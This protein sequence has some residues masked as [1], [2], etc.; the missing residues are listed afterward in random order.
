MVDAAQPLS[1]LSFKNA[2]SLPMKKETVSPRRSRRA[3]WLPIVFLCLLLA[4]V[5]GLALLV[6][7]KQERLLAEKK[8]TP[9]RERPPVNVVLQEIV[10]RPIQDRLNLPGMVEPWVDLNLMAEVGGTVIEVPVR[11]GERV[12]AGDV[13][14][15]LDSRDYVNILQSITSSYELALLKQ[16]RLQTLFEQQ[17]V[18]KAAL[19]EARATVRSLAAEKDQAA[20]K[21]QRCRITAPI[22]GV[23]NSLPAKVG[24]LLSVAD[25][26]ARILQVD[27]LKVVVGIPESDVAAVSGLEQFELTL[28]ALA[29]RQVRAAKY[30]MSVAPDSMAQVYRLEL[31]IDNKSGDILPG[32]FARV[33][34]IK[35]EVPAAAVIPL[36]S[37]I[38]RDKHNFVYVAED[39]LARIREVETGILDGWLIEITSGL[40]EGDL[41]IVVG[42]RSVDEGQPLKVARTIDNPLEVAR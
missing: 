28:D 8:A 34:I 23:V 21:L 36:Y 24:L 5:T 27:R 7:A 42:H 29:R 40:A 30:F 38:S 22:S 39:N 3:G 1:F 16:Q 4:V 2:G 20:L 32:M 17:S 19:D 14:A 31:A 33:E 6:S 41:V 13:I 11:E 26:V 9:K 18:S 10:H 25:P 12:K 35:R 15:Q 37:L